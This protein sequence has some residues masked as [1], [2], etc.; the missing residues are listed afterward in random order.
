MKAQIE[1]LRDKGYV[2]VPRFVPA[3]GLTK[4]NEAARA[5]LATRAGPLEFEADLQYP[6]APFPRAEKYICYLNN[7]L[8][9]LF[10]AI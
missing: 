4:L 10:N 6:G 1:R 3:D 5:Q 8:G 2:V 7:H 9:Y